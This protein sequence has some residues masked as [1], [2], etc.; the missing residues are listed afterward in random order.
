MYYMYQSLD[1]QNE[2]NGSLLH[3]Q[4]HL[5]VNQLE[6]I[7]VFGEICASMMGRRVAALCTATSC[8]NPMAGRGGVNHS[9]HPG[10]CG[11]IGCDI[12]IG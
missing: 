9:K 10:F 4:K 11:V 8:M 3:D 7:N 1:Q 12:L 5:S 6:C 2:E